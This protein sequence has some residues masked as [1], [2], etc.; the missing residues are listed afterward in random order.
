MTV[1]AAL[2]SLAVAS[3]SFLD[4]YITDDKAKLMPAFSVHNDIA[5]SVVPAIRRVNKK[6]GRGKDATFVESKE[7][8]MLVVTSDYRLMPYEDEVLQLDKLYAHDAPYIPQPP[9]KWHQDDV[10]AYIKDR[11]KARTTTDVYEEL[12][13]IWREYAEFSDPLYYKLMA[14]YVLQTYM[15]TVWNATGYVHFNGTAG[16]GKSRCLHIIEAT[17]YNGRNAMS[18]SPSAMF[19]TINGNP[20]VL[21]IDEAEAFKNEKD[22][23][24][25]KLLLGGYDSHGQA[26]INDKVGDTFRPTAYVTYCPKA[27][28][29]IAPIDNTLGSRTLIVPMEPAADP[30]AELP[31]DGSWRYLRNDLHV[32]ALQTAVEIQQLSRAWDTRARHANARRLINRAWQIAR[33]YL[34]LASAISEELTDELVEFFEGYYIGHRE[35]L[36]AADQ[37]A[38]VLK[39]LPKVIKLKPALKDDLYSLEQIHAVV[40]LHLEQDQHDYYR[41]RHTDRILTALHVTKGEIDGRMAYALPEDWLR[42]A[43][44]RRMVTP[45]EDDRAWLEGQVSYRSEPDQEQIAMEGFSG[46]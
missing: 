14:L 44:M 27:I 26:I 11:V 42:S 8:Q 31:E 7:T 16:T 20:G 1:E 37:T 46:W 32:W 28:A 39:S 29:S 9:F 4:E 10:I 21:C 24:V 15:Y 45:F 30:P 13:D 17:G 5:Y 19:R 3:H 38:L 18:I 41:S 36:Q 33:P 34:V 40:L 35:L 12:I 23:E 22:A 2:A 25:Y 6:V 43:F